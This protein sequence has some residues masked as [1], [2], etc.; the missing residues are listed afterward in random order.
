MWHSRL[1]FDFSLSDQIQTVCFGVDLVY[2]I[3]FIVLFYA[4][5]GCIVLVDIV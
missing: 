4:E 3:S 5:E 2:D 1:K